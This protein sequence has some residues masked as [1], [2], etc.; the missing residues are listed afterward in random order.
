[1]GGMGGK[2]AL[3]TWVGWL[4]MNRTGCCRDGTAATW[5]TLSCPR[6]SSHVTS[7]SA[8]P[9]KNTSAIP[10]RRKSVHGS[11]I[12]QNI[13]A[14]IPPHSNSATGLHARCPPHPCMCTWL[15]ASRIQVVCIMRAGRRDADD[16]VENEKHPATRCFRCICT[17]TL[18]S[19]TYNKQTQMQYTRSVQSCASL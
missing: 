15:F 16:C 5:G 1:M 10:G 14:C 3:M 4:W 9:A 11:A 8:R 6:D 2:C 13:N 7:S 18:A 19:C 17:H 12:L